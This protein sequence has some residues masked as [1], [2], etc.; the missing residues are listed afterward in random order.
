[1]QKYI[2]LIIFIHDRG[3][4]FDFEK[5]QMDAFAFESSKVVIPGNLMYIADRSEEMIKMWI[6]IRGARI[7]ESIRNQ[8]GFICHS[9][10]YKQ[11]IVAGTY[12]T[13]IVLAQQCSAAQ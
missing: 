1:M 11:Q 3:A 8:Q 12:S 9:H 10:R 7:N 4:N 2:G 5:S 6:G 13:K